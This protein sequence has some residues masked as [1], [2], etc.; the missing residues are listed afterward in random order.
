M[1][2]FTN[3]SPIGKQSTT[4]L[5]ITKT[6]KLNM[7]KLAND[8]TI[9]YKVCSKLDLYTSENESVICCAL[10]CICSAKHF[11]YTC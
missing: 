10:V 1:K 4:D 6:Q 2:N 7:K 5:T 11:L 9:E 8:T 3:D